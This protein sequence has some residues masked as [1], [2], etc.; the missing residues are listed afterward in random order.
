MPKK[1]TTKKPAAKKAPARKQVGPKPRIWL[2]KSEPD[3]YSIDDLARD[4][5][6][7]WE[8]VRNYQARNLLRD[9]MKVGDWV[10]FYHSNAKPLAIAGLA[11]ISKDG[12]P[13]HFACEQGHRYFDEKSDPD[14]PTWFM[15]DVEFVQ[16]FDPPLERADLQATKGLEGMM[17]LQKGSRLSVQP[18][19]PSEWKIVLGLVGLDPKTI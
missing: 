17:L 1:K 4:G 16:R 14:Q 15:V 19:T 9:D 6:T 10:L 8:G 11:R 2:F 13:D 7:S 18:V 5:S 12:Y 3:V